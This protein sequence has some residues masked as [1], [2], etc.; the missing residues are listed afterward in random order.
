MHRAPGNTAR[1]WQSWGHEPRLLD[2]RQAKE[3]RGEEEAFELEG[4]A[5]LSGKGQKVQ[6]SG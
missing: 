5:E 2:S 6:S 1:E 4:G 3:G